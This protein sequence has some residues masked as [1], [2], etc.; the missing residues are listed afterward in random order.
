MMQQEHD[1]P[2][3]AKALR[4]RGNYV[5]TRPPERYDAFLFLDRTRALTPLDAPEGW[6]TEPPQTW[7]SG[8]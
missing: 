6:E 7:P 8:L 3:L 4:R 5:R 1:A 2:E